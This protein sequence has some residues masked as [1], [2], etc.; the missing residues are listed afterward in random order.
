MSVRLD[1]IPRLT[2]NFAG[3]SDDTRRSC[4]IRDGTDG[5]RDG[6]PERA[7]GR[8]SRL[9]AMVPHRACRKC[10]F[11]PVFGR[12]PGHRAGMTRILVGRLPE[13]LR[14]A[15]PSVNSALTTPIHE[16][17]CIGPGDERSG[18]LEAAICALRAMR[19]MRPRRWAGRR[20]IRAAWGRVCALRAMRVMRSRRWTGRRWTGRWRGR[21]ATKRRVSSGHAPRG[22]HRQHEHHDRARARRRAP[23]HPAGGGT[24]RGRRSTRSSSSSTDSSASTR[25]GSA[26]SRRSASRRSCRRSGEA[27]EEVAAR[28]RLRILV[29][30]AGT[31]PIPIRTDRPAEVGADRLV[32]ALAAHR[33]YGAP[34][35][36]V[37]FGTATTFDVVSADGA[38]V[39]GAIAPGLELGLDALAARTAKL[40][41]VALRAPD[42]AIGRDTVSAIQSGAVLGHQALTAGLLARIRA[43]LAATTGIAPRDVKAILTGGLSQAPWVARPRGHRRRRSR[44]DP[45]RPGHPPCRGRRRRAHRARS[46]M[47]AA[48]QHTPPAA[49]SRAA[50]SPWASP[51]R[52]RRTRPR[53]SSAPSRPRAPT[54]VALLTPAATRFVAPL[55]LAALTR[56]TVEHDVL[57]LL[58][59]GRIGHI[60]AAD[61]ADAI[62]VAP[63]TANWI[64]AMAAGLAGDVVTATCL[65]TVRPGRRRPAM[66]GDM[67]AHPATRANVARLRDAF[68]YAIVEPEFGPLASG[69]TGIGRLAGDRRHRRGGRRRRRRT[70]GPLPGSGVAPAGRGPAA[71][72]GPGRPAHRHHRR[73]DRR[74]HRSGP[75]HHEPVVGQDGRRGRRGGPRSRGAGD[76]HRRHGERRPARS[77]DRHQRRVDRPDAGRA[78]RGDRDGRP[79]R[80]GVVRRARHGGGR[81]RLPA[82]PPGRDEAR[83]R[84]APDPRARADARPPR[85]GRPDR[86][87]GRTRPATSRARPTSRGRSSS[88]F[89]AETGSLERAAEKLRRKGVD[90]LV[91]NDVAEPGSGFGTETNRVTIFKRG[92]AARTPGRC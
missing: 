2:K 31:V 91:A 1:T 17:A 52:S 16:S 14:A 40:P 37:D 36:V 30:S 65:A 19:V 24:R 32:N 90:L 83:P 84:G 9:A 51:A 78:P 45:P 21:P 49:A 69:Q 53:S 85:R 55:T 81:G 82:D 15:A 73:R 35:V 62:L 56:H 20:A 72:G 61:S 27:V 5:A 75:L 4:S 12:R 79:G 38:Y 71:R 46:R 18:P 67:Y 26:R 8:R 66:D 70:Q 58:P 39:G 22:R 76:P 44:P 42:R 11:W 48:R 86:P 34:A 41:R 60:V 77:G 50:S 23:G 88:G 7:L 54:V 33:L 29:A 10:T 6:R 92:R 57:S 87:T 89:A 68:G 74:A 13:A 47:S 28:R 63:A 43:E 59:D 80:P 25:P 3:G 64:A